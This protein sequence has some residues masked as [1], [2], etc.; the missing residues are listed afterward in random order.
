M[1]KTKSA[2][3]DNYLGRLQD[4]IRRSNGCDSKYV[5]TVRVSQSFPSFRHDT[6]WQ[7]DVAVFEVYGHPKAQRAYAW[8]SMVDTEEAKYVV[9]LEIPPVSS[10][11]TAVQAAIAAQIAKG[12]F[13]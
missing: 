11:E 12:P 9:V 7:G 13:H 3:L 2:P 4:A 8:S 10:P 5:E 1:Q 6:V